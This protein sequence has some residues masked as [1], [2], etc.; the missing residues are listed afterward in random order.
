MVFGIRESFGD[1][2]KDASSKSEDVPAKIDDLAS[3]GIRLVIT[4]KADPDG[5]GYVQWRVAFY[6][7]GQHEV[8][9]GNVMCLLDQFISWK[10][11]VRMFRA[12]SVC[13]AWACEGRETRR[14]S[15]RRTWK[16]T[17]TRTRPSR[18]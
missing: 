5:V 17:F 13:I 8:A 3:A 1:F 18:I 6:V 7:A 16:S 4:D 2:L 15:V 11:A 12:R 14:I 10:A 9:L